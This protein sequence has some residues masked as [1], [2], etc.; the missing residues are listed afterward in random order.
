MALG[1]KATI[2]DRCK[3]QSNQTKKAYIEKR[4]LPQSV[5]GQEKESILKER[6][7]S[8]KKKATRNTKHTEKQKHAFTFIF[9]FVF[10][11][12]FTFSSSYSEIGMILVR[13][14]FVV[15]I[16]LFVL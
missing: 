5:R 6:K 12:I 14:F 8:R 3:D 10:R 1:G 4:I 15:S 16:I 2:P 11:S 9:V 7:S 13:D